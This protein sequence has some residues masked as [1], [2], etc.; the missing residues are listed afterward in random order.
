[1]SELY[2]YCMYINPFPENSAVCEIAWK[3]YVE[4][5]GPRISI[6]CGTCALHAW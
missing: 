4:A 6:Q 5:G 3:N 1:V 2:T